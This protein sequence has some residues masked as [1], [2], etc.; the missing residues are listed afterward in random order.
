MFVPDADVLPNCTLHIACCLT[1]TQVNDFV[2]LVRG[3]ESL[4]GLKRETIDSLLLS[5]LPTVRHSYQP[6][7][8][9]DDPVGGY[10]IGVV[11]LQKLIQAFR[12]SAGFH[13]L[14]VSML[15]VYLCNDIFLLVLSVMHC[16]FQMYFDMVY[17]FV[18]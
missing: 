15:V 13:I 12:T 4:Y 2:E 9:K 7:K 11:C 17:S 6:Y 1:V 16:L 10:A 8:P 5:M 14:D 18:L 3:K